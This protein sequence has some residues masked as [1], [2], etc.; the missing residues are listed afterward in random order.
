MA[1]QTQRLEI[2]TVRAE[3]GSN[4]VYRFAN[5]AVNADSIP[6]Q[7][8]D[9]QNLKQVV[10]EIQ[11]DAAEK[12]SIS[13]TIYPSV[14]AGLAAT[15]D[16][17]IFLVQSNDADEI[18]TVWQNQDGTAVN[19]GKTALS[20]TAIQEALQ[21]SS[22][23]AQAAEDA[24]DTATA[25]TAGFLAPSST[26][27][28]V[29]DNGLPLQ[30]GD[31]YFNITQQAER[32]YTD[33]GWVANESQ[34]AIADLRNSSD[35]DKGAAEVGFEGASVADALYAARTF[36]SYEAL[37]ASSGRAT[38]VRIGKAGAEGLFVRLVPGNYAD[39]NGV[40]IVTASGTSY[41]R[42]IQGRVNVRWFE[43][44]SDGVTDCL[45]AFSA[46]A[47]A[48]SV[49]ARGLS[50]DVD[51]TAGDWF[52][53]GPVPTGANWYLDGAATIKGRPTVGSE[54]LPM[55]DTTYLTGRVFDFRSGT[56]S[57]VRI[58]DSR[59]WL[60]QDWRPI[61]ECISTLTVINPS[62]RPAGLFA[63]RT[64]DRNDTS[65]LSYALS[66][67]VVNDDKVNVKGGYSV[68]LESYRGD[69]AGNTFGIESDFLNLGNTIS[70]DPY[71]GLFSGITSNLWLSCGGGSTPLAAQSNNLSCAIAFVP[72][73]KGFDRGLTFRDKSI[74]GADKECIVS[75]QDY[76]WSWYSSANTV[77]SFVDYKTHQRTVASDSS[78]DCPVDISRKAS[79]GLLAPS[80]G[81]L[82][83]KHEYTTHNGTSYSMSGSTQVQQ[84]TAF[85]SGFA[86]FSHVVSARN[87]DGSFSGWGL[88]DVA[89]NTAAPT[90]DAKLNLGGPSNR[91]NNSFFAVAPTITSDRRG[92]QQISEIEESC[93]R[94]VLS[95][96]IVQYKINDA[97]DQKGDR[98]RI[99]FGI[100]AQELQD[101]FANEGLDARDYGVLALDEW[102][103]V[104]ENVPAIYEDIPAI[105]SDIIDA[106]GSPI[107][108][109]K[110]SR[111]EVQKAQAVLVR[112]AGSRYGVR[113]DEFHA[114]RLAAIEWQLEN[115]KSS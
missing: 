16:Q 43:P 20:A 40:T 49:L 27:P 104:Y 34:Q 15:A 69:G 100:I 50:G 109:Q 80:A 6:T 89:D 23:A 42:L 111:I 67:S 87:S 110:A 31:R 18:Y 9:I 70:L 25:R 26:D 72:N 56:G 2:A 48:A 39:D 59:P 36:T 66:A 81:S 32:I 65:A 88:N 92:K 86:R 10:L 85:S 51:V 107:L 14:A 55:H 22:E 24:A 33:D 71:S 98:A 5:D 113:Y 101:A 114:L 103:D 63:T 62:G 79:A 78:S 90:T 45:P 91:I 61:S 73:Q 52:I 57:Q 108:I 38:L 11:Q 7:T 83:Y 75:P 115:S 29:R 28:A 47:A 37:R 97:V 95:V 76:R 54:T 44:V 60:T 77:R 94:A 46:A 82:T 12:I 4:I 13:T 8:G 74:T 41:R 3:V 21:A 53:S 19:T 99:H 106:E 68:Y 102:D 112:K 93:L 17:G 64:S 96:R 1:D 30:A 58:G 35:P 105:Y 84:K